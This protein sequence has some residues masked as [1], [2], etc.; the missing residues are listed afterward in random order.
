MD[1]GTNFCLV[2]GQGYQQPITVNCSSLKATAWYSTTCITCHQFM[3]PSK[4]RN[5]TETKRNLA[6]WNGT[7]RNETELGEMKR[8]LAKRNEM[9]QGEMKRNEM[10]I[11][12][13]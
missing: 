9:K 6:E 8:N 1:S 7:W 10:E 4:T 2:T 13:K 3:G 11:E 5:E 12:S